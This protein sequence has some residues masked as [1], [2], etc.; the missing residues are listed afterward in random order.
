MGAPNR[1]RDPKS[2][3]SVAPALGLGG[4]KGTGATDATGFPVGQLI[5]PTAVPNIP[6][7]TSWPVCNTPNNFNRLPLMAL[8]C[9]IHYP[10]V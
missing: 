5:E 9:T 4:F 8:A 1:N 3:V 10:L 7:L 2:R 6:A